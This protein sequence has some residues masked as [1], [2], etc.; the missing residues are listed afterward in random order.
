MQ[1]KAKVGKHM[2]KFRL[3]SKFKKWREQLYVDGEKRYEEIQAMKQ[4][5]I[6]EAQTPRNNDEK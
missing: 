1:K 3:C 5:I 6:N 2:P 4:M